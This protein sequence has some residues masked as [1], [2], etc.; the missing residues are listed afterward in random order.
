MNLAEQSERNL[1]AWGEVLSTFWKCERKLL[2]LLQQILKALSPEEAEAANEQ[3]LKSL[4]LK[5]NQLPIFEKSTWMEI[6]PESKKPA[7]KIGFTTNIPPFLW[8]FDKMYPIIVIIIIF[9]S[10]IIIKMMMMVMIRIWETFQASH[11]G[12][13]S[14]CVPQLLPLLQHFKVY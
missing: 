3:D 2:G 9:V 4:K 14:P 13:R 12:I 6:W 8:A 5:R 1:L 7:K 10:I 11:I